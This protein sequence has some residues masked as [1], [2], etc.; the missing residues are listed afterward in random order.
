MT[1]IVGEQH[2]ASRKN[3]GLP[4]AVG[5]ID[6]T[7][8][9]IH[10]LDDTTLD[11]LL[12]TLDTVSDFVAYLT[13]KEAFIQSG[14]LLHGEGEEDLL[15]FYLG[16]SNDAGEHDFVVPPGVSLVALDKGFWND[17]VKSD[18]RRRQIEANQ[19]SYPWDNL[20]ESFNS[21][22]RTGTLD[23]ITDSTPE[24]HERIMRSF[25]REPRTRRRMLA[26]TI[27]DM[28][29]TTPPE[30]RRI[31][32]VQPSRPGD[33]HFVFLLLPWRADQPH[34]ENR[35]ARRDVLVA[36][37]MVTKLVCPDARD[38]VG[39]ATETAR[40]A[41]GSEDAVYLDARDWDSSME[42]KAKD[43]QNLLGILTNPTEYRSVEPEY[44]E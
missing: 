37:C 31:R 20:I 17:F 8:S 28:I 40:G 44:P 18:E 34:E 4:F 29:R 1:G 23:R 13:K 41:E 32:V 30:H 39:F 12:A 43:L 3:G 14:R 9:F 2:V 19:I 11:I 36:C 16:M 26:R 5:R 22:A 42:A 27:F 15:A 35:R 7:K 10:V 24:E 6:P 33:P 25:A 21:H 38:I